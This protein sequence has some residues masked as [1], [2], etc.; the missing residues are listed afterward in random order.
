MSEFVDDSERII[1]LIR[2]TSTETQAADIAAVDLRFRD[3]VEPLEIDWNRVWASFSAIAHIPPI[4]G[5]YWLDGK[6]VS[7]LA[8]WD[9]PH[10]IRIA[11]D[12]HAPEGLR[13]LMLNDA[14]PHVRDLARDQ[15]PE[16]ELSTAPA[17]KSTSSGWVWA[18]VG[19]LVIA[20]FVGQSNASDFEEEHKQARA[21][22]LELRA[23]QVAFD[24]V[25]EG[26]YICKNNQDYGSCLKASIEMYNAVCAGSY[27]TEQGDAYCSNLKKSNADAKKKAK[28]CVGRCVTLIKKG[29]ENPW[30]RIKPRVP[31]EELEPFYKSDLSAIL[32]IQAMR[33]LLLLGPIEIGNCTV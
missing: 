9:T 19:A 26:G 12:P 22:A 7:I 17:T 8:F 1:T 10:R 28:K 16:K 13:G 27:L 5:S 29:E 11:S 18:F 6:P 4:Q 21:D 31:P 30:V 14:D 23:S 33:C 3:Y 25:E 2:D 24:V 20:F 15:F 32:E